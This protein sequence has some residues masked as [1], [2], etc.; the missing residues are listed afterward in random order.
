MYNYLVAMNRKDITDLAQANAS[1]LTQ[2]EGA[3]YNQ[4]MVRLPE[5]ERL[6]LVE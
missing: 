1:M 5:S 3:P 6:L 2:D 4:P